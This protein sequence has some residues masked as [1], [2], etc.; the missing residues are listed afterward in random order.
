MACSIVRRLFAKKAWCRSTQVPSTILVSNFPADQ[1]PPEVVHMVSKFLERTEVAS[2][3]LLCRNVLR[4]G[5]S[6][7]SRRFNLDATRIVTIG[8][9]PQ[10][11]IQWSVDMLRILRAN[12]IIS[13]HCR[14]NNE[15]PDSLHL[16]LYQVN[17]SIR[18]RKCAAAPRSRVQCVPGASIS[19]M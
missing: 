10:Q 8:F 9:L 15:I 7:W 5:L 17:T 6:I 16:E 1:L 12:P 19:G 18:Q 3:R 2:F 13:C 14:L 4:S 11:S